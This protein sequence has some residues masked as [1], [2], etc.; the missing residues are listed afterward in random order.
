MFWLDFQST[1]T[2]LSS[3]LLSIGGATQFSDFFK[4]K[5]ALLIFATAQWLNF[6]FCGWTIPAPTPPVHSS[7]SSSSSPTDCCCLSFSSSLQHSDSYRQP[8][9]SVSSCRLLKFRVSSWKSPS[10]FWN[11]AARPGFIGSYSAKKTWQTLV[12]ILAHEVPP[13]SFLIGALKKM[14]N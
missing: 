1:F 14:Q 5:M 12:C 3:A 4:K 7:S 2:I 9:A 8:R 6:T 11:P 13:L 10:S